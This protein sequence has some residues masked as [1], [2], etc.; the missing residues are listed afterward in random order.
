VNVFQHIIDGND[1][2]QLIIE[3]YRQM[4]N[5]GFGKE[6]HYLRE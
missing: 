6:T 2:Y 3:G 1:A 5:A 4:L